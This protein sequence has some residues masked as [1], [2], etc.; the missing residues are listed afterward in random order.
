VK[1]RCPRCGVGPC[2]CDRIPRIETRTRFVILRHAWEL[3]KGSN[4]GRIAHLALPNSVV[5]DIGLKDQPFDPAWIPDGSALLFPDPAKE[6]TEAP[7]TVVVLDGTWGQAK[8]MV[9][10]N[11]ALWQ[12]PRLR[13]DAPPE[14]RRLRTPPRADGMSTIEAMAQALGRYEDPEKGRQLDELYDVLWNAVSPW[15]AKP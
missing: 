5:Y 9:H 8:R 14:R 11:E 4:T 7:G 6:V 15:R 1:P 10:R 13:L 2:L 3:D 12:L